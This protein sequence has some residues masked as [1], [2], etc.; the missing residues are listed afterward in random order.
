MTESEAIKRIK[1]CMNTP[2]FQPYFY[3]NEALNMAIKALEEIQQ[4]RAIGLTPELIE[5]MQGHNIAMI[6]DLKE[7][8]EIGTVEEFQALRN[9][10][11]LWEHNNNL[12]YKQGRIDAIDEFVKE[13]E[14]EYDNDGCPNVSDYLDYKISIRHLQKIAEHLKG[15]ATDER[16]GSD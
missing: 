6:N 8:Q 13:I 10:S 14:A 3:V 15:G 11:E 1:E 5:A 4:Y 7:Y 9:A 2:N 16:T 12:A